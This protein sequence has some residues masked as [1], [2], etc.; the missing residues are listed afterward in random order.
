MV[1]GE[2]VEIGD[3]VTVGHGAV[4]H[5]AKIGNQ[6][7]VRSVQCAVDGE[8]LSSRITMQSIY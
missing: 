4:I 8:P 5:G 7:A 6:C 1:H 3:N 2:G